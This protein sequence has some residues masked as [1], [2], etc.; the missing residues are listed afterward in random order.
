MCKLVMFL[1][2]HILNFNTAYFTGHQGTLICVYK[3]NWQGFTKVS[4]LCMN[5]YALY[6]KQL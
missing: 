3:Q 6:F 4:P 5:E 2:A 1:I